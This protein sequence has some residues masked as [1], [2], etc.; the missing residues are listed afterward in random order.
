MTNFQENQW[1][2]I[3]EIKQFTRFR[4]VDKYRKMPLSSLLQILNTIQLEDFRISI[5]EWLLS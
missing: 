4:I 5:G 1:L 2:N 3:N